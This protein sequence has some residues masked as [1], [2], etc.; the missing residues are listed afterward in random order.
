MFPNSYRHQEEQPM[1]D[2]QEEILDFHASEQD[3][4]EPAEDA[5]EM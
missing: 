3:S 5:T 1:D 4:V 2:Y